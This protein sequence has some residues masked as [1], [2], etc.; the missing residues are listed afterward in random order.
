MCTPD[1]NAATNRAE[2]GRH[3][4]KFLLETDN[5]PEISSD[6]SEMIEEGWPELVYR[7]PPKE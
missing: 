1:P 5:L 4:H 3:L 7:L 2:S 6:L